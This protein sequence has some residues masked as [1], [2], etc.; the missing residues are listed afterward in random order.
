MTWRDR[1]TWRPFHRQAASAQS[2]RKLVEEL[3]EAMPLDVKRAGLKFLTWC[4]ENG[5]TVDVRRAPTK[6]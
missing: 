2:N 3:R 1:V 4:K 5:Y 6:R